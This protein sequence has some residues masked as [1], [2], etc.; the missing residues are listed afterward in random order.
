MGP[1]NGNVPSSLI[2]S[3][4]NALYQGVTSIP[5]PTNP[6][7]LASGAFQPFSFSTQGLMTQVA[8][9]ESGYSQ[10]ANGSCLYGIQ[11]S[12]PKESLYKAIKKCNQAAGTGNNIGL[13]QVPTTS[14]AHAR[15]WVQNAQDGTIIPSQNS[16]QCK[17]GSANRIAGNIEAAHPGLSKTPLTSC[18]LEE[19]GLQL[20]G[21]QRKGASGK[22]YTPLCVGGSGEACTGGS[23]Q[24]RINTRGNLCGVCY[25]V[26]VRRQ[27]PPG[28]TSGSSCPANVDGIS[29][30]PPTTFDSQCC[31]TCPGFIDQS[32][33]GCG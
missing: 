11:N 12:W 10:F 15:S 6:S 13:M 3:D 30:D 1:S 24:W 31:A 14:M 22:Y 23:W 18:Q 20:F 21:P 29:A 32:L 2:T 4:L 16:V 17:L 33:L 28:A 5:A 25:V 9:E 19:M 27:V 26:S 8:T 7:C